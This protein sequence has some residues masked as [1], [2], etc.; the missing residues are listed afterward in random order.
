MKEL[1]KWVREIAIQLQIMNR[2][3]MSGDDYQTKGFLSE[4][5]AEKRIRQDHSTEKGGEADA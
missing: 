4:I 5:N 3:T 2:N 1:T